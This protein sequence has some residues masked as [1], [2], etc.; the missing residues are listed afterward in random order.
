MKTSLR[1][2]PCSC[3]KSSLSLALSYS[4]QLLLNEHYIVFVV[5]CS[6]NEENLTTMYNNAVQVDIPVKAVVNITLTGSVFY[7]SPVFYFTMH[8]Q[9]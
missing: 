4:L 7:H 8:T 3:V 1:S 2:P 5:H 6:S 9:C